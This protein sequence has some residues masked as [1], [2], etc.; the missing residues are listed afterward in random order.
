MTA[1]VNIVVNYDENK[2]EVFKFLEAD[3]VEATEKEALFAASAMTMIQKLDISEQEIEPVLD[4]GATLEFIQE[5]DDDLRISL[6]NNGR[7]NVVGGSQSL[8]YRIAT[9]VMTEL[10]THYP[11]H[12][13]EM[14]YDEMDYDEF[15]DELAF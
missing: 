12:Y 2:V 8:S 1:R 4:L 5:N 13:D 15:D 11:D 14:D 9:S 10:E 7:N 3:G 6:V